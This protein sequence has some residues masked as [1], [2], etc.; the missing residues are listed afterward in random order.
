[1][2]TFEI[3]KVFAA[4]SEDVVTAIINYYYYDEQK[5]DH[6]GTSPFPSF[7]ANMP[8]DSP[9]ITQKSPIVPGFS[10]CNIS[11]EHLPSVTIEFDK[12]SETDVF[13]FPAE[14]DYVIRLYTQELNND[15]YSLQEIISNKGVTGSEPEEFG[16]NFHFSADYNITSLRN[17][18]LD[19]AF[20]GF[21]LMYHVPEV[22]AADG[23]TEFE[24]Y[25]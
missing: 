1:M 7:V 8:K 25:Y 15:D 13:Y 24:C 21:T 23:S 17:K 10:P 6:K 9:S 11:K 22:I 14:V 18:N 19:N 12:D 4:A 20:E 2:S 3:I 5:P 16:D